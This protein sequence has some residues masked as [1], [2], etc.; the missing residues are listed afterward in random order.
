[1]SLCN[2]Q[3]A[4]WGLMAGFVTG[5]CRLG[6]H[7]AYATP[8]CG[9]PE[10]DP[11]PSV[12]TDVH[13]LHF[14]MILSAIVFFVT[15]C[16]SFVTAPRTEKQ[17]KILA[18]FNCSESRGQG[19][20]KAFARSCKDVDYPKSNSQCRNIVLSANRWKHKVIKTFKMTFVFILIIYG[21]YTFIHWHTLFKV[22]CDFILKLN[23]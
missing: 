7:F 2:L 1:M 21:I 6:I 5:M 13:Y 22:K 9:N 12:F 18:C 20:V 19:G 23:L 11:R 15:A 4:W 8:Q 14:A 17:V 10:P 16:V 3:G